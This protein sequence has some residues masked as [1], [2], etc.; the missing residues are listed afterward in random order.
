MSI[1]DFISK[2]VASIPKSAIHEMTALSKKIED[3]AFLSWAKP[4]VPPRKLSSAD[5][6]AVIPRQRDWRSC[7]WR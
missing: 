1:E 5:S 7:V 6:Q 3:V 2:K 4:T